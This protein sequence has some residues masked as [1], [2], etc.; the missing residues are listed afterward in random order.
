MNVKAGGLTNTGWSRELDILN[1]TLQAATDNTDPSILKL[2][3]GGK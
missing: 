3:C 2:Y 1:Q